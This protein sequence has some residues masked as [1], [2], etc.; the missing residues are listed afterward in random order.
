MA[1][2]IKIC[3]IGDAD[4]AHVQSHIRCVAAHNCDV[5]LFRE[6]D[7]IDGAQTASIPLLLKLID[8][9][10][11][12]T[13]DIVHIHYAA[14]RSAW[15]TLMLKD[16]PPVIVTV[17]GGDV[18]DHEQTPLPFTAR[19]MTQ[20]LL[21]SSHVV[22]VKTSHLKQIVSSVGVAP[23]K[24]FDLMWGL[25][26]VYF[27]QNK[28]VITRKKMGISENEWVVFSPRSLNPFYNHH[29]LLEAVHAIES[30]E[31][32]IKVVF[33]DYNS[34]QAYRLEIEAFA[35]SHGFTDSILILDALNHEEMASMYS[36]SDIVVSLAPSDGFPHSVLEAMAT[37]SCC[38]V[39]RLDRFFDI[40]IDGQNVAMTGLTTLEIRSRL[41][42]I[43]NDPAI[44]QRIKINA[45]TIANKI[46]TIDA[47]A[48]KLKE[49]YIDMLKQP[50]CRPRAL[51]RLTVL[52]IFIT[53]TLRDMLCF[54]WRKKY[55]AKR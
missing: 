43:L 16:F 29:L 42:D 46:G 36:L 7:I 6:F 33:T 41:E 28:P 20:Q 49:V 17:M 11:N 4:S 21:K 47:S 3:A 10:N 12:I 31:G 15:A 32:R 40:L 14:N 23:A 1:K 13:T 44:R 2:L 18:L 52:L 55:R 37:G 54:G 35:Q 26:P 25:D 27:S 30:S 24:V 39:T 5:T 53:W 50:P 45:K 51:I 48:A 19:W 8:D 9:L 34:D 38:L 22:T